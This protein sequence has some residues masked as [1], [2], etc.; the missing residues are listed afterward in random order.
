MRSGIT[1]RHL[2]TYRPEY[3]N[4]NNNKADVAQFQ[5]VQEFS[6]KTEPGESGDV[7]ELRATIQLF[8]W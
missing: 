5:L 2:I 8:A 1:S 7:P 6:L 3:N 4:N